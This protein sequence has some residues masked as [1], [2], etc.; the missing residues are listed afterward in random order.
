MTDKI[1]QAIALFIER[2]ESLKKKQEKLRG[3]MM[4]HPDES[5]RHEPVYMEMQGEIKGLAMCIEYLQ[6]LV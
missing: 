3:K 1:E 4:S 2:K 5:K 6:G